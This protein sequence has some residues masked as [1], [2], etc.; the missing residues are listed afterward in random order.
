MR[1][2]GLYI[3]IYNLYLLG[4]LNFTCIW[5]R[6]VSLAKWTIKIIFKKFREFPGNFEK[7]SRISKIGIWHRDWKPYLWVSS[8]FHNKLNTKRM[9]KYFEDNKYTLFLSK[10]H[11]ILKRNIEHTSVKKVSQTQLININ[12]NLV[13]YKILYKV[14]NHQYPARYWMGSI[15]SKKWYKVRTHYADL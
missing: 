2:T 8:I 4:V 12:I 9:H 10:K 3:R 7:K 14:L 1:Y 11:C 15:L 6:L 13:L 5:I